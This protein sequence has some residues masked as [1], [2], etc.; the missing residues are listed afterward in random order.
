MITAAFLLAMSGCNNSEKMSGIN[1]E[2]EYQVQIAVH[3]NEIIMSNQQLE[4]VISKPGKGYTG[5]RFD[6]GG[7]VKQVTLDGRHTFLSTEKSGFEYDP[8]LGYGLIGQFEPGLPRMNEGEYQLTV[9]KDSVI[10]TKDLEKNDKGWGY[11]LIKTITLEDRKLVIKCSLDNTGDKAFYFGEYNHNFIMI[12]R[13][14]VSENYEL[15]FSFIPEM[16]SS[17]AK[18]KELMAI[19][20]N[21]I[22][23][24][25]ELND[26]DEF[27]CQLKGFEKGKKDNYWRLLHKPSGAGVKAS[28]DFE[29]VKVQLWGK[30]HTVCPEV[31]FQVKV[32]PGESFQWSRT[33]EFFAS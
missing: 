10:F 12:N 5:T 16:S 24:T 29:I 26:G 13:E 19:N 17:A 1:D 28:T 8:Q 23:W 2:S 14:P 33:Y 18:G 6:W 30:R 22:S 7:I 31:F 27:L 4:A 20:S 11:K 25:R 32:N 15:E 3:E 21:T 9:N